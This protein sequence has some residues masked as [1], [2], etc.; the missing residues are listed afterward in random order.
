[1]TLTASVGGGSVSSASVADK[2]DK[3]DIIIIP[4]HAMCHNI[5]T[6]AVCIV[7]IVTIEL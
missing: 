3:T 4:V 2:I 7:C 1:M 6:A 5:L